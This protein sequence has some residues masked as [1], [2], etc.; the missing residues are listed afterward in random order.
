MLKGRLTISRPTYSDGRKLISIKVEDDKSD[1]EFLEVLI[2][3]ESFT[4]AITGQGFI[5]V[6]FIL[7]GRE[8]IGKTKETKDLVFEVPESSK[9]S[10]RDYA[11]KVSQ[12][13]ADEGW[14]ADKY[15]NSQNSIRTF[16]GKTY[17]HGRQYRFV[18]EE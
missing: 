9:Y 10:A 2:S 16:S 18:D 15:F 4:R 8:N 13:F 3:Y 7:K 12:D 17:A 1:L 11:S 6:G 14:I 5:E